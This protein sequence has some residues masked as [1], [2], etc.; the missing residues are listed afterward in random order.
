MSQD[1]ILFVKGRTRFHDT[2]FMILEGSTLFMNDPSSS[3]S[4]FTI[5]IEI[6]SDQIRFTCRS[7]QTVLEAAQEAGVI[8]P[9]SCLVG[10]C[11]SCTALLKEGFLEMEEAMG[12]KDEFQEKG[13]V[14]LC[15]AYPKSDLHLIANQ[16]E[17][18]LG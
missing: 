4:T 2:R 16:E 17:K 6:E 5:G 1:P 3:I 9:S 13:F 12:L 18:V 15:Q 14:L 7:N 10:M 8:L 11:C